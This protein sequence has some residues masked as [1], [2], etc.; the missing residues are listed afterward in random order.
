[1][2]MVL[3]NDSVKATGGSLQELEMDVKKLG[4]GNKVNLTKN[5]TT[6]AG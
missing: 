3:H 6:P 1:M 4:G 2:A 5:F